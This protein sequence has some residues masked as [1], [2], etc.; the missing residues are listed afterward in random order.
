MNALSQDQY[1]ALRETMRTA[2]PEDIGKPDLG[3]SLDIANRGYVGGLLGAPADIGN[4]LM[5]SMSF[6]YIPKQEKPIGGYEWFGDQ[7]EKLGMVSNK[8]YPLEEMLAQFVD[9]FSS[10]PAAMG[11]FAGKGAKMADMRKL[12]EAEQLLDAGEDA[13]SVWAR[14]G[15]GKGP[16]GKWRF[17]IPDN[18]SQLTDKAWEG[19]F[20]DGNRL[21]SIPDAIDHPQLN[22]AYDMSKDG[23]LWSDSTGAADGSYSGGVLTINPGTRDPRSSALHELQHAIQEREG[24][25]RGGGPWQFE[26]DATNAALREIVDR[27][28]A[29][30]DRFSVEAQA[31]RDRIFDSFSKDDAFG[32]PQKLYRSLAG[33]A[34]A[35]LTQH[36]MNLT[37]EERLGLYP[38]EPQYFEDATGVPLDRLIY[39][40]VS[41]DVAESRGAVNLKE[42][43]GFGQD[44]NVGYEKNP[45]I[46][47]LKRYLQEKSMEYKE[48]GWRDEKPLRYIIDDKTGDSYFFDASDLH[49]QD[50]ADALGIGKLDQGFVGSPFQVDMMF[51]DPY[52]DN[53]AGWKQAIQRKR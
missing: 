28:T 22:S 19:G 29:G 53:Y 26:G 21:M 9:P 18:S 38:Y 51:N 52:F 4:E 48:K 49:H 8:R 14:T 42:V 25:A 39:R 41:P 3:K 27:E 43:P 35:R 44:V 34:E 10:L 7:M 50:M 31:I 36:R 30:L 23:F 1:N 13:A 46:D 2:I 15:W 32:Y 12:K 45:K 47:E 40:D 17:E 37:P 16:D 20:G 33:E 6:G 5:H 24:F 11:I